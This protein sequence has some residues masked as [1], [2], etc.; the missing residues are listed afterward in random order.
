MEVGA[1]GRRVTGKNILGRGNRM[2]Q[3][4]KEGMWGVTSELQVASVGTA[5]SWWRRAV[6]RWAA[7]VRG[8]GGSVSK[9]LVCLATLRDI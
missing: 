1:W 8:E 5:W 3:C 2:C 4:F 7:E 6:L 9:E